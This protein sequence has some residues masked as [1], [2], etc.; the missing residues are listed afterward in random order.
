[1]KAS[2]LIQLGEFRVD[3][4]ARTR[5]GKKGSTRSTAGLSMCC[6]ISWEYAGKVVSRDE[7]VKSIWICDSIRAVA[8]QCG[9]PSRVEPTPRHQ[10]MGMYRFRIAA[11]TPASV[12]ESNKLFILHGELAGDRTQDP[13]LKRALLYQLSYELALFKLPQ[14]VEPQSDSGPAGVCPEL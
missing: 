13:R 8:T 2:D 12:F 14:C 1:M 7:L 5:G 4:L 10:T 3:A 11:A 6:F 9:T